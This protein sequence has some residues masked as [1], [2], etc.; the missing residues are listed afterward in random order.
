MLANR[1]CL[2]WTITCTATSSCSIQLRT[3]PSIPM[4]TLVRMHTYLGA[5][6][7]DGAVFCYRSH[8]N[9]TLWQQR[10]QSLSYVGRK[11]DPTE[12]AIVVAYFTE[13]EYDVN[14]L[15]AYVD[16]VVVVSQ[17]N[18]WRWA[19]FNMSVTR[20]DIPQ[21]AN[22]HES[23]SY[24]YYLEQHYDALP[25]RLYFVQ[26]GA[27]A[28]NPT[29][30]TAVEH[31]ELLPSDKPFSLSL[32]YGTN[33]GQV[34]MNKPPASSDMAMFNPFL[35]FHHGLFAIYLDDCQ[36]ARPFAKFEGLPTENLVN[37]DTPT[38][39]DKSAELARYTGAGFDPTLKGSIIPFSHGALFSV[40]RECLQARSRAWFAGLQRF[41]REVYKAGYKL[42]RY[43]FALL[44]DHEDLQ[45]VN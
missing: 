44:C 17:G 21:S 16:L 39:E 38:F 6:R 25:A 18:T 23:T 29:M 4:P 14:W 35:D 15:R 24:T 33:V 32:S 19:E 45:R 3:D 7:H 1:P 10:S 5:P 34:G 27:L 20:Y 8:S 36:M 11:F 30:L 40:T 22:G 43:W 13:T 26:A 12:M 2:H 9:W 37:A 31:P 42:E 28:H 41:S